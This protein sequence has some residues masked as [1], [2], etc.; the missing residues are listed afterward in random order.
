MT[1]YAHT[2]QDPGIKILWTVLAFT[3]TSEN[4]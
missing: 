3:M 2:T 4:K 1:S